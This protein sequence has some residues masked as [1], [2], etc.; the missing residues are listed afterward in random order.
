MNCINI[1][2]P[3]QKTCFGLLFRTDAL[4]LPFSRLRFVPEV[5][6]LLADFYNAALLLLVLFQW[7]HKRVLQQ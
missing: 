4:F 3:G 5:S 1:I 6:A 7:R 2:D